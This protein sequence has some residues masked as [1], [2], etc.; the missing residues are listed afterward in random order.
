MID[1]IKQFWKY[2]VNIFKD[3]P[4]TQCSKILIRSR[5]DGRIDIDVEIIIY[6]IF[7]CITSPDSAHVLLSL[8]HKPLSFATHPRTL[9]TQ[10]WLST[11]PLFPSSNGGLAFAITTGPP[12][13][14]RSS[15]AFVRCLGN[16]QR[17]RPLTYHLPLAAWL[18]AAPG[19]E[20]SSS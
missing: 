15:N 17:P 1:K 8:P 4:F 7:E 12:A 18:L 10:H 5:H 16:E 2:Y 3:Q 11:S 13:A 9:A 20:L 6:Y 19:G 14:P